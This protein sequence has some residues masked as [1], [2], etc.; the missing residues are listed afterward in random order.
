MSRIYRKVASI[1]V[2][3]KFKK[4]FLVKKSQYININNPFYNQ[5][6]K[7]CMICASKRDRIAS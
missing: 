5:S 7:A 1:N 4:T 6:E 2:C 3:Y